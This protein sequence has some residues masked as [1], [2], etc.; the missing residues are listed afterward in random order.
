MVSVFRIDRLA[1]VIMFY[2]NFFHL[3]NLSYDETSAILVCCFADII[4][5]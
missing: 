4:N 1:G 3:R 2:F 5:G